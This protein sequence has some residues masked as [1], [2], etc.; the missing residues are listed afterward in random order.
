M[1]FSRQQWWSM[2]GNDVRSVTSLSRRTWGVTIFGTCQQHLLSFGVFANLIMRCTC[3][4]MFCFRCGTG[5][6]NESDR[7]ECSHPREHFAR[8]TDRRRDT[9]RARRANRVRV[10]DL[11]VREDDAWLFFSDEEVD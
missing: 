5:K 11:M 10:A 8:E 2:D 3:G 6:I 1:R 7:C 9:G 4:A